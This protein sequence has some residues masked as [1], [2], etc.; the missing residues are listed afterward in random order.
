MNTLAAHLKY[1]RAIFVFQHAKACHSD[2][3]SQHA[4]INKLEKRSNAAGVMTSIPSLELNRVAEED[5]LF[6]NPEAAL[7]RVQFVFSQ[8]G[9]SL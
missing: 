7:H 8:M 6:M 5:Q 1:C 3:F 9:E 2:T 4:L